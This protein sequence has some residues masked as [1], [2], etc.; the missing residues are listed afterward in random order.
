MQFPYMYARDEN[1]QNTQISDSPR[2]GYINTTLT[3]IEGGT[4]P[5]GTG[6]IRTQYD[7]V[8]FIPEYINWIKNNVKPEYWG[9]YEYRIPRTRFSFETLNGKSGGDA[10]KRVYSDVATG[11][12]GVI[13]RAGQQY[14]LDG[15]VQNAD[16]IYNFDFTKVTMLKIEFSWYGAVGALFL[17]YVPVGNG[18]ARW[19]RVHHLRA[20]NQLKIASLGNATL[21]ITYNTYGGGDTESLGDGEEE[22]TPSGADYGTKSHN[23]VKYGASYYIDGGDRGTVRLYSYNND[24]PAPAKGKEYAIASASITSTD[25][26]HPYAIDGGSIDL[27][28]ANGGSAYSI[29]P[30]FFMKARYQSSSRLDQNIQVVWVDS[31]T[32]TVYLSRTPDSTSGAKLVVDRPVTAYGIETKRVILSTIEGNAVRNRVQVYPTRLST[33]NQGLNPV[34]LRLQ[35]TPIFQTDAINNIVDGSGV[36][37]ETFRLSGDHIITPQNYPLSTSN[38]AGSNPDDAPAE[39]G[40]PYLLNGESLYGWFLARVDGV[41][42]TTVF[43]RLYKEADNYY[44]ELRESF[45][46][47][48]TLRGGSAG[49]PASLFQFLPDL[50]FDEDGTPQT[51]TTFTEE[52][53][54][55]LS[56][57]KIVTRSVTSIPDTGTN[58]ATLYLQEGTE[59]LELS[60]YFDYNKEYLSFP[61]TDVNET[62]YLAV[63]SDTLQ[64]DPDDNISIGITW[65]EQ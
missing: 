50:R 53:T 41:S 42:D 34:R 63:D 6:T 58:V 12:G 21:P 18:E 51:G 54:D 17:A 8:N 26:N 1:L 37:N 65:E 52:E 36:P 28:T 44:F 22:V 30:T 19:V 64:S 27:A 24:V 25:A 33:S 31:A 2:V 57:V 10:Y 23:I 43:G 49:T 13:A 32:S 59:Q 35:K 16:S 56:S 9:V 20:S 5:N 45:S 39:S 55:G 46:G 3:G 48:V 38:P 15:V 11:E 29:D 14:A 4:T 47:Q 60:P 62:L 61:L 40:V 7:K